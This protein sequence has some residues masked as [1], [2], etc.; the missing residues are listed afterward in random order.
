MCSNFAQKREYTFF[1][2]SKQDYINMF[3]L[4]KDDLTNKRIIDY[5]GGI[6]TFSIEMQSQENSS[7]ISIG[8]L[9]NKDLEEIA[10]IIKTAKTNLSKIISGSPNLF[11]WENNNPVAEIEKR[12]HTADLF[13]RK[14]PAALASKVYL[15]ADFPYILFADK[16]FDLALCSHFLFTYENIEMQDHLAIILELTRIAKEVRIF[17]LVTKNCETSNYLVHLLQELQERGIDTEIRSVNYE[18]QKSG[19]AALFLRSENTT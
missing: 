18:F 5:M 11:V 1:G 19:N 7:S 2:Y 10:Q 3:D 4:Q 9:Y 14:F 6:N 16:E 17:P 8:A 15:T 13:M 12:M